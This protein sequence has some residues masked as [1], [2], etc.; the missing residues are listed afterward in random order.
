MATIYDHAMQATEAACLASWRRDLLT[1]AR[2]SV[3]ELGAGTGANLPHYPLAAEKVALVEPD[4]FMRRRLE[5]AVTRAP[6]P[7]RFEVR[8]GDAT[9][10]A[11]ADETF[12]TVVV[13]LVLCSVPDLGAALR[14]IARVLKPEGQLLYLEHVAA[15]HG[16][17]LLRW[18]RRIEPLWKHLAGGCH[19][20][21]E[22]LDAIEGAGL[23]PM[24]PRAEPMRKAVPWVRP[25]VRGRA[26]K[27]AASA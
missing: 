13:T 19:L 26:I 1:G 14:E 22:T 6:S 25:T 20:T 10:L 4:P 21:R 27:P 17:R 2:G 18:Q 11:F 23:V 16:S 7:A 15:E 5:V 9:R 3:L 8:S 24:Y 12:D